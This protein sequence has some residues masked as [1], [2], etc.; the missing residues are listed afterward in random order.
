[1]IGWKKICCPVDFSAASRLAMEQAVELARGSGGE[2]VLL[3]V[4]ERP[5]RPVT[6][7][8]LVSTSEILDLAVVE[9]ERTLADWR[10]AAARMG[11]SNVDTSFL[12]GD[13]AEEIVRFVREERCELVVMS[14]HG[15][16]EPERAVFGSVAEK[17][18][19]RA[20]CSVLVLRPVER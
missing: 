1:M 2:L 14:T 12:A 11:A 8:T 17:V 13:P 5:P 19:R 18:V 16:R 4:D 15:R 7:D 9:L 6:T 10:D 3:H 20:G